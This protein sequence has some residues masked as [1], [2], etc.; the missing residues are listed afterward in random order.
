[1]RIC[2]YEDRQVHTLQP[3]TSTRPVT[4]LL[5]GMTTL[6]EKHARYF[7]VK[8]GGHLC[9]PGVAD[10]IRSHDPGAGVNDPFWLRIAP[11]ILVNARWVP[12]PR[13]PEHRVPPVP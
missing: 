7:A 12:P 3:L 2:V 1:M 11:T 6:A 8:A 5:C 10:L 4:D 13:R 9:R